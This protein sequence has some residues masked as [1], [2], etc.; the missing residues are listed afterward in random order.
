MRIF[1]FEKYLRGVRIMN[2][3]TAEQRQVCDSFVSYK[4]R[5]GCLS[6]GHESPAG[7]LFCGRCGSSLGASPLPH[8]GAVRPPATFL[9]SLSSRVGAVTG[10]GALEGFHPGEMFSSLAEKHSE[11]ET[12]E[13]FI[14]G[15]RT[16]TPALAQ[17]SAVWPKP[18]VFFR[19]FVAVLIATAGLAV[20]I[21]SFRNANAL[22]GFMFLGSFAVPLSMLLFYFEANVPRNVSIYQVFRMVLIGGAFSLVVTLFEGTLP[23]TQGFTPGGLG[24]YGVGLIEETGKVA[25]LLLVVRNLRFPWTLNGL[26]FGGAIGAGFAGFESA[27]YAYRAFL[28]A[29]GNLD[30]LVHTV[31]ERALLAPGGHVA[32]A[33]LNGAALW[34]VRG[35]KPFAW[36]MLWDWRFLRVFLFTIALH[37][38]WDLGIDLPFD[39]TYI[40]LTV[41]ALVALLGFVQDGI[42]QVQRAQ[43][44]A[45]R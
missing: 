21:V 5:V 6:C 30:V 40:A 45:T 23:G 41:V 22:P 42:K 36:E 38:T 2:L 3:A 27:G 35:D 33:A 20:C 44:A 13:S 32:W 18:W 14:V 25:A 43:I 28:T 4:R 26:L 7:A 11:E 37:G 16:T 34:M 9:E 31:L 19:V 17:I 39:G 1:P 29:G 10:V 8:A 15:T 12:E 24:A